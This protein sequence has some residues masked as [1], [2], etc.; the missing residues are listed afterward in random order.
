M[1]QTRPRAEPPAR[2]AA[3]AEPAG[4]AAAEIDPEV[5]ALRRCRYGEVFI[6]MHGAI[7]FAEADDMP[8]LRDILR[9]A[10]L[11]QALRAERPQM[12]RVE[13][14]AADIGAEL[15]GFVEA[16]LDADAGQNL[17]VLMFSPVAAPEGLTDHPN[18]LWAGALPDI[19]RDPDAKRALWR[20]ISAK[21]A[22]G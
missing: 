15:A 10:N 9:A 6:L 14:E 12:R 2:R 16:C 5:R 1:P 20:A 18:V 21:T 8:L 13:L 11:H 4:R 3:A 22:A 19:A 7:P 17:R